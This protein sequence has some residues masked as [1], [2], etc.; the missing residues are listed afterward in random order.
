M[1]AVRQGGF[2]LLELLAVLLIIGIVAAMAT[3]SVGSAGPG[4]MLEQEA[5]RLAALV[6]VSCEESVLQGNSLALSFG[7]GGGAYGFLRQDGEQWLPRRGHASRPRALPDG[8]RV[9]LVQEGRP[10]PL[11]ETHAGRPHLVCLPDGSVIPFLVRFIGPGSGGAWSVRG[12]MNGTIGV[13]PPEEH[14]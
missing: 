13:E 12:E 3:L 11:D 1:T 5:E 14:A 7:V 9:E 8:V 10:V 2:S 4:R 6:R